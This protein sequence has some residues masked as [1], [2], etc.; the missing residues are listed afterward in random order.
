MGRGVIDQE[1]WNG[2]GEVIVG[3][4]DPL[5][6]KKV[7]WNCSHQLIVGKVDVKGSNW[8][9]EDDSCELVIAQIDFRKTQGGK[10][11][12]DRSCELIGS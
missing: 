3:E 2:S 11:G 1:C 7:A 4:A 8:E 12:W 6:G 9:G 5:T 10:L